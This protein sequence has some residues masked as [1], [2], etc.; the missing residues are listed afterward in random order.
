MTKN[1]IKMSMCLLVATLA[2]MLPIIHCGPTEPIVLVKVEYVESPIGG[3]LSAEERIAIER[4]VEGEAHGESYE[5]KV[6][7]ATCIYNSMRYWDASAQSVLTTGGYQG[8]NEDVQPDTKAA[9]F[10]VFDLDRPIHPSVR[11]FYAPAW[12]TSDWHESLNF[13]AEIGGHRF[14]DEGTTDKKAG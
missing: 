2:A 12:C 4:T 9:V 1:Q 8:Y 3:N 7:V 13:V 11:Y 10:R 14:F 5:G 6:W